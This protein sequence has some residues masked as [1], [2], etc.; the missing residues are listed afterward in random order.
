MIVNAIT[1]FFSDDPVV[2]SLLILA[3][4]FAAAG[5][6]SAVLDS[7]RR[8][9]EM[10]IRD[11]MRI[12]TQPAAPRRSWFAPAAKGGSWRRVPSAMWREGE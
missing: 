3:L 6:I 5:V 8:R 4:C 11:A 7:R 12:L 1:K 9:E 10:S 2:A